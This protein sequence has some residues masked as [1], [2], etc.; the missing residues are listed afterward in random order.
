MVVLRDPVLLAE[1]L[2][3]A[4]SAHRIALLAEWR[5]VIQV[6]WEEFALRRCQVHR[7]RILEAR[8]RDKWLVCNTVKI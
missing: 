7:Y 2:P 1:D 4:R 8:F 5:G 6:L 3:E